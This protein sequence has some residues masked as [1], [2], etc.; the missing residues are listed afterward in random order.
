MGN[1]EGFILN[2]HRFSPETFRDKTVTD[3]LVFIPNEYTQ[4]YPSLVVEMV[5]HSTHCTNR[6]KLNLS[7]QVN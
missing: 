3:K 7:S 1:N 5:G 6:A 2:Y 4:N